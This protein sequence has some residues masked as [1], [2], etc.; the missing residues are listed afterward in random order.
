[1]LKHMEMML[2]LDDRHSEQFLY[3]NFI[4]SNHQRGCYFTVFTHHSIY[5]MLLQRWIG[6]LILESKNWI[7]ES[8]TPIPNNCRLGIVYNFT[9]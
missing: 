8:L 1:M 9:E 5:V 2:C 3:K 6:I 7:S 4:S